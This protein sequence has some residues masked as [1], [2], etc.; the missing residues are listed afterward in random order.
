M[1]QFTS[2]QGSEHEAPGERR[3]E[4]GEDLVSVGRVADFAGKDLVDDTTRIETDCG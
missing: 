2:H 3:R 4:D 1:C